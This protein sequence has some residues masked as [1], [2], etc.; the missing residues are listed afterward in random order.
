MSEGPYFHHRDPADCASLVNHPVEVC[1]GHELEELAD[2]V[3][4][5]EGRKE[6]AARRRIARKHLI[7]RKSRIRTPTANNQGGYQILDENNRVVHGEKFDLSLEAVEE[8]AL[9]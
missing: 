1:P 8:I 9:T 3:M 6:A 7:L 2:L 4:L 5:R